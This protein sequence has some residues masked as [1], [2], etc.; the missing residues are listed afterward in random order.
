MLMYYREDRPC[1]G[2]SWGSLSYDDRSMTPQ[3]PSSAGP[4]LPTPG[5]SLRSGKVWRN[6]GRNQSCVP[7]VWERPTTEEEL[8]AII[9]RAAVTGRTVK[10]VGSGHSYSAI[11]C[12]DGHLLDLSDYSRVLHVDRSTGLVTAQAGIPLWRLS[13]ELAA[14][15]LALEV[16]GDINYQ[17]IA[18]AISTG[19]HGPGIKFS[20]LSSSVR[21]M[22]LIAGDG[23]VLE[24]SAELHPEVFSAARVGLGALGMLST[25]TIQAVPAFNLHAVEEPLAM[26]RILSDL[27][28]LIDNNDH[29]GFFWF[30]G[31][32]LALTKRS[33][34]TQEPIRPRTKS[35]KWFEEVLIDNYVYGAAC[36]V[37]RR[38][39]P[40][41]KTIVSIASQK[42]AHDWIDRSD[43]VFATPR[44]V[45]VIEME[46]SIP[47]E[48]FPEAF[49]RLGRLIDSIGTPITVPIEIRWSAG[50]NIPLS[51][52]SGRDS[53]YIA[54]HMF[55]GEPYDQYFQGVEKIMS[56]YQGRPHW[57]KLHF[58]NAETLAPRYPQW[59]EF[60]AIRKR[61]DPDGR[62]RNPYTDRVLGLVDEGLS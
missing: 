2:P 27:D 6:F 53:A 3:Q 34:R 26:D 30:P 8:V 32:K 57:G 23:T 12:T 56:D 15:G 41:A 43:R 62:F 52:A 59:D 44:L 48:A 35:A 28:D 10:A 11:A 21:A 16:L 14:H 13:E 19:T 31:S 20:N 17:S 47:R 24:C 39:P 25:V 7:A 51:H 22:R 49:T 50:D 55:R 54:A 9:R 33:R 40:A 61:M 4:A 46:Y 36:K 37:A 1:F 18:G 60:Q 29:F 45:R 5:T 58:Q 42:S 38:F